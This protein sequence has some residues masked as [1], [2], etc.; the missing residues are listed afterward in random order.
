MRSVIPS[1]AMNIRGVL[2]FHVAF[3]ARRIMEQFRDSWQSSGSEDFSMR[4]GASATLLRR[5]QRAEAE[6]C[7]LTKCLA[8]REL[9][10]AE[11]RAV[12][13]HSVALHYSVDE[14]L[15]RELESVRWMMPAQGESGQ[16]RHDRQNVSGSGVVIRLP[17]VTS[18]LSVL[19]D[20]MYAFWADCDQNMPPKSST[21]ARA[22]DERLNLS[23]QPNGEASRSGQAYASAI[24]PDWVKDADNRHHS[25]S[26]TSC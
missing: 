14:R 24:R 22:I 13:A 20:A 19:F 5:V 23:A 12:L 10:V 8:S 15:E 11:L 1:F 21:V 18:V 2:Q 3:N 25:R 17:Y 9:Q 7:R 26:R 4:P 16:P 6:I